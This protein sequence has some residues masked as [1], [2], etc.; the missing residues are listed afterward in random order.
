MYLNK[1]LSA[2]RDTQITEELLDFPEPLLAEGGK[3][4]SLMYL[5]VVSLSSLD[6][7]AHQQLGVLPNRGQGECV[8]MCVCQTTRKREEEEEGASAS[9][10]EVK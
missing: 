9:D 1:H 4:F 2:D 5:C 3:W 10:K 6:W 7:P 8:C